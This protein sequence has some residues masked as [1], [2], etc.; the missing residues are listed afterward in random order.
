MSG[1]VAKGS[2]ARI[3]PRG[4][5]GG[6]TL[7]EALV[8]FAIMA[9]AF[10][11][12]LQAFGLG[13]TGLSRAEV[14][15][16]ATLQA[17]SKMAEVGILFPLEPDRHAGELPEGGTW[18]VVIEARDDL[19]QAGAPARPILPYRVVVEVTGEVGGSVRL[20]TLRL[21]WAP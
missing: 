14:Y 8:A 5:Q 10:T 2:R 18:T 3:Q 11:A 9:V 7:L 12:L 17:R 16:L 21:G 6:F 13:L 19:G 1:F 15:S 4:R 20:E